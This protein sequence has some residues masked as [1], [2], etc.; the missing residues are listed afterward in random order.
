[1]MNEVARI[2]SLA[3]G[4]QV[5]AIVPRT[6]EETFRVARAVVASKLYDCA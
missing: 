4:A 6:F 2:P 3:G 5:V 1:M